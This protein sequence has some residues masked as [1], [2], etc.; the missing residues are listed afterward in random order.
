LTRRLYVNECTNSIFQTPVAKRTYAP[1]RT[2]SARG[3]A[4]L[5]TGSPRCWRTRPREL[6]QPVQLFASLAIQAGP[7]GDDLYT[8][9][10]MTSRKP[11]GRRAE[12][13]D[14]RA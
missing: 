8:V 13:V 2:R 11:S 14:Q 9:S 5:R 10:L 12:A 7:G 3:D 1:R 4:R 6:T